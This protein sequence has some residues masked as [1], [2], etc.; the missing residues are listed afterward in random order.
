M[1][2][3]I[4]GILTIVSSVCFTAISFL[5]TGSFDVGQLITT[6]TAGVGL[7]KAADAK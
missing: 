7:I 3:T 1:K 2:T 4:I 5:K 6:V